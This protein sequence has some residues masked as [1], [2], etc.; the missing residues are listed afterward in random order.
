MGEE[1]AALGAHTDIPWGVKGLG[2]ARSLSVLSSAPAPGTS[3]ALRV[4]LLRSSTGEC[5]KDSRKPPWPQN[6][7]GNVA[8]MEIKWQKT[9][10]AKPKATGLTLLLQPLSSQTREPCSVLGC[11]STA[12]R[13]SQSTKNRSGA[14]WIT[15]W[16]QPGVINAI[17]TGSRNVDFALNKLKPNHGM[18]KC[19]RGLISAPTNSP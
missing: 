3:R 4:M 17:L 10:E 19:V 15:H 8:V 5:S 9:K 2:I 12:D 11:S 7:S 13:H 6:L 1:G 14:R 16:P 18:I